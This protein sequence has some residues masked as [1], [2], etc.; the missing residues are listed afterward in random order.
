GRI[1]PNNPNDVRRVTVGSGPYTYS[2]FTGFGLRNFTAPRGGYKMVIEGC[3]KL[4]TDW[5]TLNAE[6]TLPPDTRIEFRAKIADSR[7]ELADPGLRAYGPWIA[8]ADN[9]ELPADLAELPGGRFMEL[10]LF[11]VST[12]RDATPM[13]RGVDVR[14]Q[15]QI[16][17]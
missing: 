9:T 12:D 5:M 7:D 10:E 6:A 14:F 3:E 11:L 8:T 13:L 16:E 4:D 1:D 2:D 15:C 17:E